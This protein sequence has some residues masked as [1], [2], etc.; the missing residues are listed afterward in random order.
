MK[1]LL[2]HLGTWHL[3]FHKEIVHMDLTS[4]KV[5]IHF[6]CFTLITTKER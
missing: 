1:I 6:L 4:N 3:K 5:T 2:I